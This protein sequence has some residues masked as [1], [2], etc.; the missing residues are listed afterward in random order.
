ML[1]PR[2][3]GEQ[4]GSDQGDH[5]SAV[6]IA[7]F[8]TQREHLDAKPPASNLRQPESGGPPPQSLTLVP[9]GVQNVYSPDAVTEA[10]AALW[11][12]AYKTLQADKPELILNLESIIKDDADLSQDLDLFSSAA[13][14]KV[15]STQKMR[16][17]NKQWTIHWFDKK[18]KVRDTIESIL[19]TVQSA[20]PIIAAGMNF[21]PAFVSIPWSFVSIILPVSP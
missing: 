14:A 17:E 8:S 21:A 1:D 3:P 11:E 9:L 4:A 15:V 5:E 19:S 6:A 7:Q 20:S 12:K 13:I 10:R 18:V 16:M 2:N